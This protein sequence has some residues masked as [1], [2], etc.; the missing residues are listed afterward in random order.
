MKTTNA[1]EEALKAKIDAECREIVEKFTADLRELKNKY[2]GSNYYNL[3]E[4]SASD[5]RG[6]MVDGVRGVGNAIHR[7]ILENHGR[8][9]LTEKS[10]EL[11]KKLDLI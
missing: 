2:G 4:S 3:N 6:F 7:M 8:A 1:I 11:I 9:M 5:A 10:K